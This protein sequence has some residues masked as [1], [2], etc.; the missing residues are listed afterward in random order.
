MNL[1]AIFIRRPVMTVLVMLTILF[2]G[3]LA[4]KA[5]PVSN[6]PDVEF[7][8]IEVTVDYPG[9]SPETIATNVVVPLEQQ[10]TTIEGL[11]TMSSTSYTGSATMVLQF[12]LDRNID[13][14]APDVQ[15][16][17][18]AAGPQL[19]QNLPYA[20]TYTKTNP[21]ATP[22]LVY[23]ISSDTMTSGDLYNYAYV[24]LAQHLNIIEGVSQV[25]TYGS[26]YAVRLRVD[27]EKLHA[28]GIGLDDAANAMKAAN[29]NEPVGTLFGKK[30]EYTVNATGQLFNASEFNPIIIK[31]QDGSIV[32]FSDIGTAIDST[33]DDKYY[34]RFFEKEKNAPMVAL[35][36]RKEPTANTLDTIQRIKEALPGLQVQ[37]PGSI[38]IQNVF[39]QSDY[40][41]ESVKEVQ[42]TLAIAI[43]LVVLVI[44][45]YLGNIRD[46]TI[47]IIAIPMSLIGAC[48]IMYFLG[49]T[50]DV[51]SLL[52]ITLSIG[53]LVDDAVVVLENIVRHTEMGESPFQAAL[54]GTKE[55]S[56]T[57][58]SMTLS[59][60]TI[61]IPLVFMAGVLGKLM[62]EF[63]LTIIIVVLFSGFISLT[64]TPLLCSRFLPAHSEKKKKTKLELFSDAFNHAILRIYEPSLEWSL[65]HKFIILLIGASSLFLSLFFLAKMPKD[66]MPPQDSGMLQGFVHTN[67]GT[68]PFLIADYIEQIS[69]ILVA[70]P[71]IENVTSVGANPQ[72][73]EGI[74]YVRLKPYKERLSLIPLLR[75]LLPMVNSFPGVAVYL[76]PLPL[77]NLQVGTTTAKAAYQYTLL[78]LNAKDLYKYG[79]MME[80]K[81][82]GLSSI[83]DVSSDLDIN[84]PQAN[85]EILRD[86]AS[87]YNITAQE[88]E[89]VLGYAFATTNLSPINTDSYQYYAI[90]EV[91]PHF[92][93]DTSQL[94]Q[95]WLRSTT[96]DMVPLAAISK[97]TE[98]IGPL[99]VNHINGLPSATIAFNLANNVPLGT[100]IEDIQ[101]IAAETLPPT[102]NGSVQGTANIFLQSFASLQILLIIAIF[103][104]YVILGILYENFFPPI[105]VM[106]TLPPAALG[107]ILSLLIFQMPLSMTAF[108][109][110]IMLLGIVMKNGIIMI[111]FANHMRIHEDQ[112][113]HDAIYHACMV[114]CRPIL[115]TT[116][117]AMMGAVPIAL[118]VGGM[119]AASRQ[120]L[121]IVIVGGLIF[122]QILTLYLTPVIYIYIET[123]HEKLK[124]LKKHPEI[125]VEDETPQTPP[126]HDAG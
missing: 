22:I 4:Y 69:K 74:M 80:E 2:F 40:I 115:M 42:F 43:L 14:A 88:I 125:T 104:I 24:V 57:I 58:L 85:I 51:L 95:L 97:I 98:G 34:F 71:N 23:V 77:V 106:S 112:T 27:P 44:F 36:I 84:Q 94:P 29:V 12:N 76:K 65:R 19:P 59:L 79:P 90:M 118:G 101:K 114:R 119:S 64:L 54:N 82:K 123:L 102:V 117:A 9:A 73:N 26:P 30:V 113:I 21:T 39:D 110:F 103:I 91:F 31:N 56:F 17:I 109:G 89:N 7:P 75:H 122:S 16:A 8:T 100:A 93:R 18:S 55:I 67:D 111:D 37:I 1:S 126:S 53:F 25:Q 52:A 46:T 41:S 92:Y 32:R 63:A 28:R 50:I 121:G 87:V 11:K 83:T 38:H 62:H 10:F 48:V 99:T 20:P 72:D 96:N 108:I 6:L 13:L 116:F 120:P 66:F 107:G 124:K 68:S 15:Q 61:F 49:F 47:P 35:A 60:C 78:T 3:I 81:L 86:K 45:I 105:T 5:L 33:Q 70:D